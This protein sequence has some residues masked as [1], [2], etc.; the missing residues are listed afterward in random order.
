M[1]KIYI[2]VFIYDISSNFSCNIS[3]VLGSFSN[4]EA[5]VQYKIEYTLRRFEN[6]KNP[7]INLNQMGSN[8]T[9]KNKTHL[10]NRNFQ[11][12]IFALESAAPLKVKNSI[13]KKSWLIVLK[14]CTLIPRNQRKKIE[15]N[16]SYGYGVF[17]KNAPKCAMRAYLAHYRLLL[18]N[19]NSVLILFFCVDSVVSRCFI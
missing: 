15:F 3:Y 19:R 7:N 16:P 17:S 6:H 4:K 18:R 1:F 5:K 9:H 13:W 12:W 10:K 2:N 8:G 14:L 11:N